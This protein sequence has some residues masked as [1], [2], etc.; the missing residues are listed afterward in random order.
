[1]STVVQEKTIFGLCSKQ[2][3]GVKNRWAGSA[4]STGV[5]D[6]QHVNR[7]CFSVINIPPKRMTCHSRN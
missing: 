6:S 5:A 2:A 7:T 1:M 4:V 3:C